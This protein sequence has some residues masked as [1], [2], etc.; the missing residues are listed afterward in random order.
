MKETF[1]NICIGINPVIY[2][3]LTLWYI[4]IQHYVIATFFGMGAIL[5]ISALMYKLKSLST[6]TPQ[7]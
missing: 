6:K 5:L 2:T 3:A 1:N 4:H 7:A